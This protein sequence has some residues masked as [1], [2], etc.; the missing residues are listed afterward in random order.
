MITAKIG[1]TSYALPDEIIIDR[2][3][4]TQYNRYGDSTVNIVF[5]GGDCPK[6]CRYL[7]DVDARENGLA[8]LS[9]IM[10]T[11]ANGYTL[12]MRN[13]VLILTELRADCAIELESFYWET[14]ECKKEVRNASEV[15][16]I[17]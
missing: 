5:Y 15:H 7:D 16:A 10:F 8:V 12:I 14:S 4:C 1:K 3:E 13:P 17:A 6:L 11:D 2:K 9:R